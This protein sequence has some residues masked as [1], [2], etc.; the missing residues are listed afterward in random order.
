MRAF[1][2][3]LIPSRQLLEQYLK[4]AHDNVKLSYNEFCDD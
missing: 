2:V 4:L 3:F 1:V